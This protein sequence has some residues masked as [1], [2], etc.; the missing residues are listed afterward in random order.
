LQRRAIALVEGMV[1]DVER[2][3]ANLDLTQGALFSQRLLLALVEGGL[4]RDDAYRVVQRLA[5]RAVSERTP[6]RELVGTEEA[7]AGLDLD[8]IFD[9]EP[10]VRY[11][12]E[13]VGRLDAIAPSLAYAR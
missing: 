1:I 11:A 6:L 5:Q 10:F 8:L 4:S 7:A 12:E 13:I 3:R 9:Y 2:M